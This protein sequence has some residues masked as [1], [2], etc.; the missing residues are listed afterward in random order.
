MSSRDYLDAQHRRDRYASAWISF[1]EQYD[2]LLTPTIFGLGLR[3]RPSVPAMLGGEPYPQQSDDW[4]ALA[5]P[6]NLAGIPAASVPTG[7]TAEGLPI[8]LQVMGGRWR[9]A[10]YWAGPP[11]S[12]RYWNRCLGRKGR[13]E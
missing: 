6:A 12:A 3:A 13:D 9:D 2:L 7:A 11:A 10:T 4:C 1:F 5:F 8:G